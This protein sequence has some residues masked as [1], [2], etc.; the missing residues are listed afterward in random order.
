MCYRRGQR[1]RLVYTA[2]RYTRLCPGELGTVTGYQSEQQRLAIDWDD[3]SRLAM[4]PDEGDR[5]EV[6][7][8]PDGSPPHV[9][10]PQ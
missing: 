7:A 9:D 6:I 2:D 5:I 1:V 3:G 4:L 8:E 10:H